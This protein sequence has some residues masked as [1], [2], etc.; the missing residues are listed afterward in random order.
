M[1]DDESRLTAEE[2]LIAFN[3][4]KRGGEHWAVIARL[5]TIYCEAVEREIEAKAALVK[6]EDEQ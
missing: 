6:Q 1:A 4:A 2:A 5:W 3:D